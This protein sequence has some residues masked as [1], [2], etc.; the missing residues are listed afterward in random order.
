MIFYAF[1]EKFFDY[2]KI[3]K[4]ESFEKTEA[5][6]MKLDNYDL[7]FK[8]TERAI[9]F[10]HQAIKDGSFLVIK[11]DIKGEFI[12]VI[13]FVI[14]NN[15]ENIINKVKENND[16]IDDED[17]KNELFFNNKKEEYLKELQGYIFPNVN[18]FQVLNLYS[19]IDD[20]STL[21]GSGFTITDENKEDMFINIIE[22]D[23]DKLLSILERFLQEREELDKM[24]QVL[25]QFYIIRD[26]FDYMSYWDYDSL[27]EALTD[28]EKKYL[29][30]K[31]ELEDINTKTKE[32]T[33]NDLALFYKLKQEF[34]KNKEA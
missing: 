19:F 32:R 20:W 26:D 25:R 22:K 16:N 3:Y 33:D 10:Y 18:L 13:D 17:L 2:Y 27:E 8:I 6:L 4:I 14:F 24:K 1:V 7:A 5:E 23:D 29:E 30:Y 34:K 11:K 31:G 9:S 15:P 21:F 12:D 28:L